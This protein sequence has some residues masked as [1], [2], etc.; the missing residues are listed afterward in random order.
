MQ[1]ANQLQIRLESG[2]FMRAGIK[3]I[4]KLLHKKSAQYFLMGTSAIFSWRW[5]A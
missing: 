1:K 3:Q 5:G 2:A 4:K